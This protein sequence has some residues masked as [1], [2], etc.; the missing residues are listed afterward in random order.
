MIR[1]K[2]IRKRNEWLSDQIGE[3]TSELQDANQMLQQQH[4]E[5]R[6]KA[7]KILG[8]QHEL[9]EKKYTLERANEKLSDWSGF[10]NKLIGILGHD[11]RGPMNRITG[12]VNLLKMSQKETEREEIFQRLHDSARTVSSLSTDLL[13]WVYLQSESREIE[14]QFFSWKELLG[15]VKE[16][17]G[18]A[19]SEK[20]ISLVFA[21]KNKEESYIKGVLPVAQATLRNIILNAVRY[22]PVG[23]VIEIEVGIGKKGLSGLRVSDHGPGFDADEVNQI[24]QGEG[25][26]NIKTGSLKE[27]AGLGLTLCV[28]MLRRTGGFLEAA[29]LPG[30]GGTFF[31]YLPVADTEMVASEPVRGTVPEVR[32]EARMEGLK[33]KKLLLIDDDDELRWIMSRFLS[34]YMEITEVRSAEEALQ[35]LLKTNP[36]VLV[37]DIHMGEISGIELC[38]SIKSLPDTA[39]LPC[40]VIS[41][42]VNSQ[43]R[44]EAFA[45]GADAFI[46]KPFEPK[47]I[48]FQLSA[49]FQNQEKKLKRFFQ[50]NLP[51]NQLTENSISQE[52]LESLVS[53]IERN[54]ASPTL[55]IDFLSK[56]LGMSKSTLYRN[57][58]ILTGSSAVGFIK[59][60]R[61][62]KALLLLR[63]GKMNISEVSVETGFNSPAYFTTTFKKHFGF[64]PSNLGS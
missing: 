35:I 44:E 20:E 30:W 64:S 3:K 31:L 10:Q 5:D 23:S 49:Y 55:T 22:S 53:L 25:F 62:R 36:D 16:D 60:I 27:S 40:I 58:K 15:K 4:E 51:V 6:R 9:L 11:L 38:Q 42:D 33:G 37:V 17:V 56:E 18:P 47:E 43:S 14:T 8:Q 32:A 28:D 29:S 48:L 1:T 21:G 46:A 12:L 54:L 45:S 24:I 7:E 19:L 63:E 13:S 39:H 2:N 57:L 26:N 41:G 50:D 61:M 34:N 52:F 59:N